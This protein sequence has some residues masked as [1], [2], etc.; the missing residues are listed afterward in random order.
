VNEFFGAVE[1]SPLLVTRIRALQLA[2]G[3]AA[4]V[5]FDTPRPSSAARGLTLIVLSLLGTALSGLRLPIQ[6]L[7]LAG[8]GR[9]SSGRPL[10]L[11]V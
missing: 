10:A 2:A 4:A 11:R 9:T 5:A 1:V 3:S 7:E 6:I 8:L